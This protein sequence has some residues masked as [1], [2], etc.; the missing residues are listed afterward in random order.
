ML[1]LLWLRILLLLME[2]QMRVRMLVRCEL[3]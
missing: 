1:L 2:W 3:R